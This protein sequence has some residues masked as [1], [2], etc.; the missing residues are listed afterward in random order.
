ME[1]AQHNQ[2]P[3]R[4]IQSPDDAPNADLKAFFGAV[5]RVI[6]AESSCSEG[7]SCQGTS[8]V[9]SGSDWMYVDHGKLVGGYTL[10]DR[11]SPSER[12]EFDRSVPFKVE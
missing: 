3:L 9:N 2:I 6:F 1:C 10:R 11:L 5:D 12:P 4:L 7:R 8:V